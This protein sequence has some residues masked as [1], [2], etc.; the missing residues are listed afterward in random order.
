MKKPLIVANWKMNPVT[1]REAN[2]LF[3]AVKKGIKSIKKRRAEVVICPPVIYIPGFKSQMPDFKLGAQNIFYKKQGAYTG[4]ISPVMLKEFGC[5]YVIIGHSERRGYLYETDEMVN[6]KIKTTISFKMNPILCIGENGEEKKQKETFNVLKRQ[7]KKGLQKIA[8]EKLQKISFAYEPVW[9][10]G[11]G[12]PCG[13]DELHTINIFI[14][15]V[16]AEKYG[17]LSADNIKVL[18]GGSVNSKNAADYLKESGINGLLIGGVSLKPEEFTETIKSV[19]L[20]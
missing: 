12:S 18:Y 8:K 9:A 3:D 14:R 16:V 13:T 19:S 10:I 17:R 5:Q 7:I 2:R 11:S 20:I 15:K 6:E 1:V 4:E